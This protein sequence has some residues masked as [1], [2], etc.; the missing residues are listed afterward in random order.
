MN[1]P[2]VLRTPVMTSS[3]V[4]EFRKELSPLS[5]LIRMPIGPF[6]EKPYYDSFN[7]V[8]ARVERDGG[9]RIEGWRIEMAPGLFI[10]A[11]PHCIWQ[12][13][14]GNL[15]D[16]TATREN[17]DKALFLPVEYIDSRE[18]PPYIELNGTRSPAK[19]QRKL[20]STEPLIRRYVELA[21]ALD[22]HLA[23]TTANEPT[24][25]ARRLA[26][27]KSYAYTLYVQGQGMNAD[28]PCRSGKKFKQ[29]HGKL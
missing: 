11:V 10:E 4:K 2:I 28:C 23:S 5:M 29:C 3:A 8:N 13:S 20:I 22:T 17:E 24:A 16:I 9:S 27:A 26:A 18:V 14:L 6:V 19:P 12:D 25:L 15:H 7:I 21:N 1:S